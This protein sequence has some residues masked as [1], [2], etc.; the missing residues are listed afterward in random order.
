[1]PAED[2]PADDSPAPARRGFKRRERQRLELHSG[3]EETP[4]ALAALDEA[5]ARLLDHVPA[6]DIPDTHDLFARGEL[7]AR[8][9]ALGEPPMSVLASGDTML[10]GRSSEVIARHG[11]G[12]PFKAMRPL[13]QRACIVFGNLEG[14]IAVEASSQPRTF[15]YRIEPR[16]AVALKRARFHAMTLA[17]N[18]L[19]DCG[20]EG[21]LETLQALT[22]HG[23]A[24]LGAG[25][26]E[27]AAHAPVVRDARG[28]RVA[29][30][31]YYWNRRTAARNGLPGSAMDP[32]EALA[33]DIRA[34]RRLADRVV[35]TFHWGVPY[36]REPS[37]E[38]RAKARHAIDCG[39]DA[40]IGHHVHVIQPFEIWRDKPIFYG[41][42]NCAFGSGNS[43][44]EGLLVGLDFEPA[45]TR[46][47]VY[48]LYV[49]NRDPRV[50]YQPKVLRGE[51]ARRVLLR[52]AELSGV[53]GEALQV[54]DFRATMRLPWAPVD[55]R[56]PS[57]LAPD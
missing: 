36:V 22:R 39:A 7:G 34:A 9:A 56:E 21:V 40:V 53:H 19:T 10:G 45:H 18:H 12:Y 44:A 57:R 4:E 43:K 2:E 26:N 48:A 47:L 24:P 27:H 35:V 15:S 14:P 5:C 8:L 28:L 37:A 29:L 41:L 1:V 42:G 30:L 55:R 52:L 51:G 31:G 50:D 54:D 49:K 33:D 23:I 38:D 25:V 13:L 17:N 6:E 20:R 11:L 3:W 46:V 16:M 32:P